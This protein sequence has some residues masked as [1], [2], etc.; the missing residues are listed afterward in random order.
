MQQFETLTDALADLQERG[1]VYNFN[2][3]ENTLECKELNLNLHPEQFA[4]TE[5]YRFEGMTDLADSSVVYA[6]E[7][8][9]GVK[10]V[11]V[12]A[13]GVYADTLSADMIN[14]LRTVNAF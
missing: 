6:I 12:N 3:A 14:K 1:Y 7:S 13:Y 10:G 8:D 2:L 5:Y 9:N 11:L 4:I